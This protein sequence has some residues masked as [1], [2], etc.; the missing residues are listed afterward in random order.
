MPQPRLILLMYG[1]IIRMHVLPLRLH[2]LMLRVHSL[3][4]RVDALILRMH[5]LPLRVHSLRVHGL[6]FRVDALI[7]R[8]HGLPLRV[9]ALILRVHGLPLRMVLWVRGLPLWMNGFVVWAHCAGLVQHGFQLLLLFLSE[10]SDQPTG[11][12]PGDC[13]YA[14]NRSGYGASRDRGQPF[15][16]RSRSP[17]QPFGNLAKPPESLSEKP[18]G[19]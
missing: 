8:V 11:Q 5:G 18:V 7:L 14:W 6:P 17:R 1:L 10:G 2:A 3:P 12:R 13:A 16:E 4:L 19:L 15:Q 9:H